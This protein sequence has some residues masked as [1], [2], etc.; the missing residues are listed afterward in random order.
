MTLAWARP[1]PARVENRAALSSVFRT[2]KNR[3]T[4][5]ARMM[6]MAINIQLYTTVSIQRPKL[7]PNVTFSEHQLPSSRSRH[8]YGYVEIQHVPPIET[9]MDPTDVMN[10]EDANGKTM[11]AEKNNH[12]IR[13][14]CFSGHW[15]RTVSM[16]WID[17]NVVNNTLAC[18][19]TCNKKP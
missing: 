7:W 13:F 1:S 14:M 10:R 5:D 9:F 18:W 16:N 15:Y 6:M 19:P 4:I 12:S 3:R 8:R 17:M 2:V 11:P